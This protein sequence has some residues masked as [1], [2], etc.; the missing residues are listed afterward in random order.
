M[1]HSSIHH[2]SAYRTCLYRLH[3]DKLYKWRMCPHGPVGLFNLSKL[4]SSEPLYTICLNRFGPAEYNV[5][6]L[7]LINCIYILFQVVMNLLPWGS[8]DVRINWK[9]AENIDSLE[10][11]SQNEKRLTNQRT[12]AV[13]SSEAPRHAHT[14]TLRGWN[15]EVTVSEI[16][17]TLKA[18]KATL[19]G[20]N[21]EVTISKTY[22]T[23]E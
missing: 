2:V 5:H 15:M 21:T 12:P 14:A 23:L 20:W 13:T 6:V 9:L 22:S 3:P 19:K 7:S 17:S 18:N 11:F 16:Y 10:C 1:N 8:V 4:N